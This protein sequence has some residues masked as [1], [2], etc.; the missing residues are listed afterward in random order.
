VIAAAAGAPL[1]P[2]LLGGWHL[3]PGLTVL[4]VGFAIAYL[5]AARH[6]SRWP[7]GRTVSFLAGVSALLLVLQ[8]GLDALGP[9]LLSA[10]MVEHVALMLVV[11]PLL[12]GGAPLTLALRTLRGVARRELGRLL[13]SRPV[14]LLGHPTVAVGVFA[15]VVVGAHAPALYAVK[16]GV[17]HAFEHSVLLGAGLIL[18]SPVVAVDPV[19]HAPSWPARVLML[20]AAMPAMSAVGVWLGTAGQPRYP[21][22]IEPAR[23]LGVSALEDQRTA[24]AVMWVGGSLV[25]AAA[26]LVLV[27]AWMR[28]E[29]RRTLAREAHADAA[30]EPAVAGRLPGGV[31]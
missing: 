28:A 4:G 10:H 25:L 5:V 7:R 22:Y 12:L 21:A 8:S 30:R 31:R 26:L 27:P 19:P 2:G 13:A 3:H 15:L 17:A 18:W 20:L 1:S 6:A 11:P 9:L 23:A 29:E 16:D 14:R 24:A